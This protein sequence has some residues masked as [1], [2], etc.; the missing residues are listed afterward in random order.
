MITEQFMM[1]LLVIYL[2]RENVYFR[3]KAME[4]LDVVRLV[5]DAEAFMAPISE[6]DFDDF[7]LKY[8]SE[9]LPE[10]LKG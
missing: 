7:I 9:V 1:A 3:D 2:A 5:E 8:A 6:E 10:Y 4:A